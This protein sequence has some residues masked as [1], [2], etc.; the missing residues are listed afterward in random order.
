MFKLIYKELKEKKLEAIVLVLLMLIVNSLSI[1]SK[2]INKITLDQVFYNKK[3]Q[4]EFSNIKKYKM[5]Y[6]LCP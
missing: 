4:K 5:T 3:N 2:Y 6:A 1:F